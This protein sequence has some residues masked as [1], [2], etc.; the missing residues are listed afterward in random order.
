MEIEGP[1]GK[2]QMVTG[3]EPKELHEGG[4]IEAVEV[5]WPVLQSSHPLSKLIFV[6]FSSEQTIGKVD[7][8]RS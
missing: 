1:R 5:T 2:T 4:T 6:L 8:L 7:A 3:Y